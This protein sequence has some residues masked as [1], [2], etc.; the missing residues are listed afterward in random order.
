MKDSLEVIP[1]QQPG[2]MMGYDSSI[3]VESYNLPPSG[4]RMDKFLSALRRLWWVPLLTVILCAGA[5]VGIISVTQPTYVS[6]AALWETEKFR[7]PDSALFTEDV[8]TAL[9]THV[10]LLKSGK[11]SELAYAR[12]KTMGANAAPLDNDGKPVK[13]KM[14]AGLSPKSS[15]IVVDITSP[16]PDYSRNYLNALLDEFLVYR[17]GVRKSVSGETLSSIS[18][19]VFRL[20]RELKAN[21]DALTAF[22][23]TNNLA[24]LQE[25]ST[26]MGSY[27]TK[28]KLQISDLK[29]EDELLEASVMDQ[30]AARK[31]NTLTLASIES[32]SGREVNISQLTA[33]KDLQLLKLERD[34]LAKKMRHTHPKIVKL[35][36]DIDR[37]QKMIDVFR[38]QTLEQLT[39]TRQS[40]QKKIASVQ[41]SIKEWEPKVGEATARIAEADHLK[42]GIARAQSLY[43]RFVGL[44]QNV[45]ISRNIDQETLAILETASPAERVYKKEIMAGTMALMAGLALG[46]G[47][48]FRSASRDDKLNSSTDIFQQLNTAIV[49]QIPEI[50]KSRKEKSVAL[51]APND[52]RHIY[53]EAYRSL[54][55]A[56]LFQAFEVARPKVILIT[57]AIPEE[58]KSTVAANLATTMALGGS[59][60]LLI[61]ADLR[62]GKLHTFIQA[63]ADPGLAQLLAKKVVADRVIQTTSLP[64]LSFIGRGSEGLNPSDLFLSDATPQLFA[65]LRTKFDH[66]II[67]TCPVFAADDATTLAPLVDGT[68]FVVRGKQTEAAMAR[69][70]LELLHQ[71]QVKIL[72]IVF[73]GV[74]ASADS[75]YYRYP[76]YHTS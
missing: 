62:K 9:G 17:K 35:N 16:D 54:R 55:S 45:D 59:R 49:G 72:G 26:A 37:S 30:E 69:E 63:Q 2:S 38:A 42:I 4:F 33:M 56:L 66:I 15:V 7:L 50:S 8:Q 25:E 57:S 32:G 46:F 3:P 41:G 76:Q 60:V 58:G 74:D 19:Q 18:E 11:M 20:E 44:L 40:L 5:G 52:Q 23:R 36:N 10:E 47:F 53:A 1:P 21:Q 48:V 39:T 71:R 67:D 51:I 29:L 43:D 14:N 61:D 73:N 34:R 65:H 64:N 31:S 70:A 22:E 12:L 28:L 27:L 68:L 24:V 13:L 75:H 6:T